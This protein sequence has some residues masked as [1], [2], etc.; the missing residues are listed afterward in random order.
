MVWENSC[1]QNAYVFLE[2][3]VDTPCGKLMSQLSHSCLQPT[4]N[5]QNCFMSAWP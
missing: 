5:N 4:L 2:D 3:S 1:N